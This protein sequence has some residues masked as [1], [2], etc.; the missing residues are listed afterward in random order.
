MDDKD[1]QDDKEKEEVNSGKDNR[2]K[3]WLVMFG[4]IFLLAISLR[5]FVG[6]PCYIPSPSMENTIWEGDYIWLNKLSY[7]AKLPKRFADIPL[8]NIFTW[9]KPLREADQKN[10]FGYLRGPGMK[11]PSF[12]DIAVFDSRDMP[13]ALIVKRICGLPGDTVSLIGGKLH[14]N[15]RFL[16][17]PEGV[18]NT[19]R[20]EPA[21]FPDSTAWTTHDYGPLVVPAKEMTVK[22]TP[23]NYL[24]IQRLADIEGHAL[25]YKDSLFLCDGNNVASYTFR[26][27]YYF[28]LGDNRANSLDSRFVGFVPEEDIEG[29]INFVFFSNDSSSPLGVAFRGSRFLKGIE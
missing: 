10:D 22:L 8:V 9:I 27:D 17:Q 4:G 1:V 15:G 26:Q 6:Q 21:K 7:G 19:K 5:V 12:Y 2:L 24:W 16:K 18:V 11:K 14:V 25:S 29:M 28:M 13:G 20:G 23:D 3:S